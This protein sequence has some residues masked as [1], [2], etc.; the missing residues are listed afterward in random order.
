[1]LTMEEG[2]KKKRK[3]ETKREKAKEKSSHLSRCLL[4]DVDLGIFAA[5]LALTPGTT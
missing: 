1:M 2:E 5:C 4:P 3:G